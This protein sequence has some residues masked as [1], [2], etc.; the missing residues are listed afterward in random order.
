MPLSLLL[1]FISNPLNLFVLVGYDDI[2]WVSFLFE[3]LLNFIHLVFKSL[4]LFISYFAHSL[5]QVDEFNFMLLFLLEQF[6]FQGL[7]KLF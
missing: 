3:A 6:V 7:Y 5:F 4:D 2:P 1:W